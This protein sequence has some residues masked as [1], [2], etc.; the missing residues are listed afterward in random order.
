MYS[1]RGVAEL[2]RSAGL[3]YHFPSKQ[4]EALLGNFILKALLEQKAEGWVEGEEAANSGAL[5]VM[6]GMRR[7]K[8]M[9]SFI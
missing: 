7:R 6:Q 4:E 5:L 1:V 9:S 2:S 8:T 3:R